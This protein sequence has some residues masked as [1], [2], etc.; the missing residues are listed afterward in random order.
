MRNKEELQKDSSV[1]QLC[2]SGVSL[3]ILSLDYVCSCTFKVALAPLLM[4]T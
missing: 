2:S 1:T 3:K 4:K